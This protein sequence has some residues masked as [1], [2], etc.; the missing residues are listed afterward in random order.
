[1]HVLAE[2]VPVLSGGRCCS[3]GPSWA[4]Q[5]TCYADTSVDTVCSRHMR[6]SLATE[7]PATC[8]EKI[9]N[10]ATHGKAASQH[11]DESCQKGWLDSSG[12]WCANHSGAE[13]HW[14]EVDAGTVVNVSGV[15]TQ[16]KRTCRGPPYNETEVFKAPVWSAS[17]T[18]G[19][20]GC[21]N[22]ALDGNT[23]WCGGKN[24]VGQFYQMDAG[25]VTSIAGVVTQG[26]KNAGQWVKTYK[27]LV[28]QDGE[29]WRE[30]GNV[31]TGNTD[32]DT[33][34]TN[35][36]S[37]PVTARYLR[38]LPQ[39]WSAQVMSLRAGLLVC[40]RPGEFVTFYAVK[41]SADGKQWRSAGSTF[42]G[43]VDFHSKVQGKFTQAVLARYVRIF[44]TRWQ[45]PTPSMRAG[46]T[47]LNDCAAWGVSDLHVVRWQHSTEY[48]PLLSMHMLLPLPLPLFLPTRRRTCSCSSDHRLRSAFICVMIPPYHLVWPRFQVGQTAVLVPN[49]AAL[50]ACVATY[51][52]A[53]PRQVILVRRARLHQPVDGSGWLE[54]RHRHTYRHR[55]RAWAVGG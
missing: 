20:S 47:I 4:R 41:V 7:L 23:G 32:R 5:T 44:P 38:V 26:S 53:R 3:A 50:H 15:V 35:S 46:L 54:R 28:S 40:T 21:K 31:Y 6:L 22:G 10:P 16:G 29:Q 30:V 14:F 45:G 42:W 8:D 17:S 9:F 48:I 52:G 34:V 24:E 25:R 49:D 1:M 11:S 33:K 12:S 37:E 36:F 2:G 51:I 19:D 43:N 13:G 55:G 39:T 27:V 18:H